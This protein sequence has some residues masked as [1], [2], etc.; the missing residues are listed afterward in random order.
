MKGTF[1]K[2]GLAALVLA[3]LGAYVYFVDAKKPATDEK[4]KQKVFTLDK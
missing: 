4:P 2:T 1:L 3:G